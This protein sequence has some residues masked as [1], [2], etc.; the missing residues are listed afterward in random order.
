MTIILE[1]LRGKTS[2]SHN[3]TGPKKP[4][5]SSFKF[6]F[7]NESLTGTQGDLIEGNYEL[8]SIVQKEVPTCVFLS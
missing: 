5:E 2:L 8:E 7:I 4:T 3:I 1:G 6:T